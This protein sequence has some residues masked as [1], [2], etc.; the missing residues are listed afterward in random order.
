MFRNGRSHW[1]QIAKLAAVA[2]AAPSGPSANFAVRQFASEAGGS[3]GGKGI[4][5]LYLLGRCCFRTKCIKS[6]TGSVSQFGVAGSAARC[7]RRHRRSLCSRPYG[8]P[9]QYVGSAPSEL[10]GNCVH[11]LCVTLVW[12]AGVHWTKQVTQ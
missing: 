5:S 1:R 3:K 9:R 8:V 10:Q 2:G 11:L 6:S 7:W 4:V 12:S